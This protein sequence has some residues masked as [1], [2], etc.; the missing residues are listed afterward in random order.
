MVVNIRNVRRPWPANY[1]YIGRNSVWGNP[2]HLGRDGDR[3][4]VIRRFENYLTGR[5]DLLS[6]LSNLRGKVLVCHCKPEACHGDVIA[7][8]VVALE[9]V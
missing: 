7:N 8:R 4:A 5:P 1:V 6:L 2:Y 3:A 9:A